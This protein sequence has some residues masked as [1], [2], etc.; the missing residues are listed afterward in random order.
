MFVFTCVWKLEN[1]SA[2]N[3][4]HIDFMDDIIHK[5]TYLFKQK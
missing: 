2:I 1:G 5:H 3:V 4:E